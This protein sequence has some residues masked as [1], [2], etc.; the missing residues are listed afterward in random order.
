MFNKAMNTLEKITEEL[1]LTYFFQQL[2]NSIREVNQEN[3]L[4]VLV[5]C[6]VLLYHREHLLS[7]FQLIEDREVILKTLRMPLKSDK[8]VSDTKDRS[9]WQAIRTDKE[10]EIRAKVIK[11][12]YLTEQVIMSIVDLIRDKRI[13]GN[14]FIFKGMN[15]LKVAQKEMIQVE[16]IMVMFGVKINQQQQ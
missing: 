1:M 8:T 11:L 5:R 16:K 9:Q 12:K 6:N 3:T 13:F 4:K 10:N 15:Y 2:V 7:I 14:V